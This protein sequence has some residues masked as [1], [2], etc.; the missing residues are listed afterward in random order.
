MH[1]VEV[2]GDHQAGKSWALLQVAL[3]NALDGKR[4][5]FACRDL[6]MAHHFQRV[7][8]D[9]FSWRPWV[10]PWVIKRYRSLTDMRITFQSGG[11]V[12]FVSVRSS[13]RK[14]CADVVCTDEDGGVFPSWLLSELASCLDWESGRM[15]RAL[16]ADEGD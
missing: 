2:S 6:R 3:L 9:D 14:Y 7:L 8:E 4:V 13:G 16:P 5:L 1:V 12:K 15:Y 11:E 10:A